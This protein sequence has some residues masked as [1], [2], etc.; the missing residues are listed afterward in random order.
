MILRNDNFGPASSIHP[1]K[2]KHFA[3]VTQ[4]RDT[5]NGIEQDIT[6]RVQ[7]KAVYTVTAIVRIGG[8][9]KSE[10]RITIWYKEKNGREEF[11][12]IAK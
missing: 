4:R 8:S 1:L 6:S 10:I 5:W 11:R 12:G 7:R 9:N 2:G 3:V